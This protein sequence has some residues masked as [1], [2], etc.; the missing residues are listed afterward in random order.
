MIQSLLLLL[1]SFLLSCT[2]DN[3]Q[4]QS[5]SEIRAVYEAWRADQSAENMVQL[6]ESVAQGL[7]IERPNDK[8]AVTLGAALSNAM[9]RPDIGVPYLASVTRD[10][11]A[12]EEYRDALARHD[13]FALKRHLPSL[14]FDPE[15]STARTLS[16]QA[17]NDPS[18]DWRTLVEGTKAAEILDEVRTMQQFIVDESV[19]DVQTFFRMFGVLMPKHRFTAVTARSTTRADKDPLL[20]T[21]VIEAHD[22]RRRVIGSVA[23]VDPSA[24]I[25]L[26]AKVDSIHSPNTITLFV[27]AHNPQGGDGLFL[28]EGEFTDDGFRVFAASDRGRA[29]VAAQAANAYTTLISQDVQQKTAVE[30]VYSDFAAEMH[31]PM[32]EY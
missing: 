32:S 28:M 17:A 5:A 18:A 2:G 15:H 3:V 26:G 21:G 23:N 11:W 25:G 31:T 19:K 7:T 10:A 12:E 8:L 16:L 29:V 22:G 14:D 4:T 13:P 20:T 30:Q 27:R 9:L 6:R 1:V 24:L